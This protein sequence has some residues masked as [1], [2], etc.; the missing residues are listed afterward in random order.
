MAGKWILGG[1]PEGPPKKSQKV[2][3]GG[4]PP[5][6][7]GLKK[8]WYTTTQWVMPRENVLRIFPHFSAF[9]AFFCA[10]SAFFLPQ[11]GRVVRP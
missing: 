4:H 9:S 6:P 8:A 5:L 1:V 10:F 2:W 11:I 7:G 3:V